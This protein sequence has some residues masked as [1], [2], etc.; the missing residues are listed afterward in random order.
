[1][2]PQRENAAREAAADAIDGY[3]RTRRR[4]ATP[5]PTEFY[6]CASCELAYMGQDTLE[7]CR[8]GCPTLGGV[9]VCPVDGSRVTLIG[10]ADLSI[11]DYLARVE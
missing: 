8:P 3:P 1:M 4:V 6:H 9:R 2:T 11:V 10:D 5:A 7:L